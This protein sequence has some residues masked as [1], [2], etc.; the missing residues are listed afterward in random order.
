MNLRDEFIRFGQFIS[1]RLSNDQNTVLL[2]F[3]TQDVRNKDVA[4]TVKCSIKNVEKHISNITKKYRDFYGPSER[5]A[6]FRWIQIQAARYYFFK[7][8]LEGS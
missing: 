2:L 7:N 3:A 5:N 4:N 1:E 6:S 8:L